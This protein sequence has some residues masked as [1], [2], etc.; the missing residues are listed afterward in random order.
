MT[1]TLRFKAAARA[2][3]QILI[4]QR[5][6]VCFHGQVLQRILLRIKGLVYLRWLRRS[7]C[8]SCNACL[9]C[10][11]VCR[12]WHS[13]ANRQNLLRKYILHTASNGA[14]RSCG[15][16]QA[17]ADAGV[18]PRAYTYAQ[19]EVCGVRIACSHNSHAHASPCRAPR[20]SRCN[21]T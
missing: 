16:A 19:V 2:L 21:T 18:S 10:A 8:G 1:L 6:S 12:L 3:A 5:P 7:V 17:R 15:A 14:S 11:P 4:S 13:S 20:H 9:W